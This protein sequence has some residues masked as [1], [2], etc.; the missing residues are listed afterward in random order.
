MLGRN[1]SE[2]VVCQRRFFVRKR[3]LANENGR[4]ELADT[5][6]HVGSASISG[7][8]GYIVRLSQE[9]SIDILDSAHPASGFDPRFLA[10]TSTTDIGRG[11]LQV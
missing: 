4:Y 6:C 9:L 8:L 2:V 7:A 10:S 1:G 11:P 5:F 3:F